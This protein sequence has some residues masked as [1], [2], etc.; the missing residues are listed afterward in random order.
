MKL[1]KSIFI[2]ILMASLLIPAVSVASAGSL[3]ISSDAI[4]VSGENLP[5]PYPDVD[6]STVHPYSAHT[7]QA[8]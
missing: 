1:A 6:N 7:T 5:A 3:K 8:V 2:Y 4:L